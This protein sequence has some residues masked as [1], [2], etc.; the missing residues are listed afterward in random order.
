MRLTSMYAQDIIT[1]QNGDEIKAKVTEISASEIRYKRFENL[2]GPTIVIS[3]SDV[4]F[5]NYENGMREI[6]TPLDETPTSNTTE[7]KVVETP[8]AQIIPPDTI[9]LKSGEKI[10]AKEIQIFSTKIK[11]KRYENLDYPA[12]EVEISKVSA[13]HYDNGRIKEIIDKCIAKPN[14]G[15][16]FNPGGIVGSGPMLG[17]EFSAGLFA[18]EATVFFPQ[19]GLFNSFAFGFSFGKEGVGFLVSPKFYTNRIKGGFYIGPFGGYLK[20]YTNRSWREA[21]YK[22]AILGLNTGYKFVLRS[23]LYFR[24]GAYIGTHHSTAILSNFGYYSYDDKYGSYY[25][26]ES[27]IVTYSLFKRLG[28]FWALDLTI[29]FKFLKASR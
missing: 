13:I 21:S 24:T 25:Y 27:D 20:Y 28:L 14:F 2:E 15:V 6:I 5:I 18:V 12:R 10:E 7:T 11:Y 26:N 23:G 4:F 29:G 17:A 22:G 19:L 8:K 16:F 1:L 9:I 3:R